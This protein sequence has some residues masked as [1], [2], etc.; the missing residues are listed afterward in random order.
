[1]IWVDDNFADHPK[2]IGLDDSAV[3]LWL[4]ALGYAVRHMTDGK[5][6][7]AAVATL[8]RRSG[9][10]AAKVAQRL[11]DVGLW[12][13]VE[14]GFAVHKFAVYQFTRAETEAKRRERAESGRKGAAA[15]WQKDSSSHGSS[16]AAPMAKSWLPDAPLP[17]PLPLPPASDPPVVP[18]GGPPAPGKLL[19]IGEPAPKPKG[20]RKKP[21]RA[22]PPDWQPNDGHREKAR[23]LGVDLDA[24][25]GRFK[26]FHA[27]RGSV[28]ADWDAALRTW[29]G[30][31]PRF[32]NGAA[33]GAPA[34]VYEEPRSVRAQR[35]QDREAAEAR[36]RAEAAIHGIGRGGVA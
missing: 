4:R 18:Q 1:M 30:N 34:P 15:R 28:F 8:A 25:V 20:E 31:A 27:A 7:A 33:R 29:L 6:P 36:A 21:A 24:E 35:V 22:C 5:I 26:D 17:L 3:A 23:E 10:A 11:V 12:E 32:G 9:P 14:D 13:V 19:D 16:H 2:F